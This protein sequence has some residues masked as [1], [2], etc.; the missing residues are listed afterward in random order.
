[1]V[2]VRQLNYRYGWYEIV[3]NK[4]LQQINKSLLFQS[5]PLLE[6]T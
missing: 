3:S 5:S 2:R 4:A 6:W 1:M